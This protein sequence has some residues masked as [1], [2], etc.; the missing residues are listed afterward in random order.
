MGDS[1]IHKTTTETA[2]EKHVNGLTKL[3]ILNENTYLSTQNS[4]TC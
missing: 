4:S 1:F 3:K 2:C